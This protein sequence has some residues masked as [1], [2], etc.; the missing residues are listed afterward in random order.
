MVSSNRKY[1]CKNS[2]YHY[3]KGCSY[4]ATSISTRHVMLRTIIERV[5]F[6]EIFNIDINI[7]SNYYYLYD[8]FYTIQ[9]ERKLKLEK[10]S[11]AE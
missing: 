7:T 5:V 6:D 3:K 1:L 4:D 11:N 8:Y 2:I 10:L 9:E